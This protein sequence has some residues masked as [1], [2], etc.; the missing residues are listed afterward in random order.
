MDKRRL[1]EMAGIR[2][3]GFPSQQQIDQNKRN[4]K[5][6]LKAQKAYKD[7]TKFL[8]K[9]DRDVGDDDPTPKQLMGINH[10]VSKARK[11]MDP[12]MNS[13]STAQITSGTAA[14]KLYKNI[15]ST[16]DGIDYMLNGD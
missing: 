16:L 7:L 15:K 8:A 14:Q 9:W 12:W 13:D 4:N 10:A 3:S 2:E 1:Q 5:L 11:D 6:F